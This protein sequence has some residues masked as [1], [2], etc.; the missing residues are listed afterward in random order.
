MKNVKQYNVYLNINNV[1]ETAQE[2]LRN[3]WF[4]YIVL[5]IGN[6]KIGKS[7]EKLCQALYHK[8]GKI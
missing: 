1:Q 2:A 7:R 8:H 4:A 5:Y 3:Y 6:L